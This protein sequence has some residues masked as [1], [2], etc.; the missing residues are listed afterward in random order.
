VRQKIIHTHGLECGFLVMALKME[1]IGLIK[2]LVTIYK[3]T[4]HNPVIHREHIILLIV[5]ERE[6]S[7]EHYRLFRSAG[8]TLKVYIV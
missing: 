4:R 7:S 8:N 1:V 6:F 2:L 5:S 3:I